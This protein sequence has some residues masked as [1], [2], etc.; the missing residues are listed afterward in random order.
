MPVA[1]S[2][3]RKQGSLKGDAGARGV[4]KD[5]VEDAAFDLSLVG[6]QGVERVAQR[7]TGKT[8]RCP[9]SATPQPRTLRH[10]FQGFSAAPG[11]RQTDTNF[12]LSEGRRTPMLEPGLWAPGTGFS[13]H[14]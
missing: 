14:S 12:P 8:P 3:R 7:A 4:K 11:R 9:L 2:C 10:H 5:H 13:A 6:K 1:P